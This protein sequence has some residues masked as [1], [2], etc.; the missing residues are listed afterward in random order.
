MTLKVTN[1]ASCADDV[2]GQPGQEMGAGR[3]HMDG[4]PTE[5]TVGQH[6]ISVTVFGSGEPAVIVEP[7]FGG[8]APHHMQAPMHAARTG[9]DD[10]PGTG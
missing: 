8:S 7:G 10:W 2:V 3:E 4:K 6:R 5:V 1:S 9:R